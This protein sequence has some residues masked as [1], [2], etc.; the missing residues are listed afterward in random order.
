MGV[1]LGTVTETL[2][3]VAVQPM[4][5][6]GTGAPVQPDGSEV[7]DRPTRS[8]K[9]E[10]RAIL[11]GTV[12]VVPA[13]TVATVAEPGLRA[14]VPRVPIFETSSRGSCVESGSVEVFQFRLP[15]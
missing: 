6:V 12:P 10:L 15:R 5:L 13:S 9:V 11:I 14:N 7:T 2:A 4:T 8:K 3:A 1:S